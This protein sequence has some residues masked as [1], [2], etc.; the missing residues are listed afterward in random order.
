MV[1]CC[2]FFNIFIILLVSVD[3]TKCMSNAISG[4]IFIPVSFGAYATLDYPFIVLWGG[5]IY[6][7]YKKP[8]YYYNKY[9]DNHNYY[10]YSNYNS[11]PVV[12]TGYSSPSSYKNYGNNY[13][14]EILKSERKKGNSYYYDRNTNDKTSSASHKDDRSY[15]NDNYRTSYYDDIKYAQSDHN[16]VNK[17]KSNSIYSKSNYKM[18]EVSN[19]HYRDRLHREPTYKYR[20]DVQK[21]K[22][23]GY[24]DQYQVSKS[25]YYN[26]NLRKYHNNNKQVG[27]QSS[28]SINHHHINNHLNWLSNN[29]NDKSVIMKLKYYYDHFFDDTNKPGYDDKSYNK[30]KYQEYQNI[31]RIYKKPTVNVRKVSN[32]VYKERKGKSNDKERHEEYGKDQ[33]YEK[34][35]PDNGKNYLDKKTDYDEVKN[36]KIPEKKKAKSEEK[37][38]EN[39]KQVEKDVKYSR[40]DNVI[41]V[42]NEYS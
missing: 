27:Y 41:K 9:K 4:R 13:N 20:A 26:D 6:R 18:P 34:S 23:F 14:N 29:N 1:T 37:S 30:P 38:E 2:S 11:Q 40:E 22:K 5:D 42:I 25:F 7:P 39:K 33:Y 32:D 12:S 35:K 21:L 17:K 36:K 10:Y 31:K 19:P 3:Y 28:K 16:T 15:N 24:N 8:F